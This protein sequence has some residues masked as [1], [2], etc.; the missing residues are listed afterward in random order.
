MSRRN[1]PSYIEQQL[2]DV[3]KVGSEYAATIRAFLIEDGSHIHEA[4]YERVAKEYA[5][6]LALDDVGEALD[7]AQ[8]MSEWRNKNGRAFPGA[9]HMANLIV[10]EVEDIQA[11]Y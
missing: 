5:R 8:A 3:D 6:Q 4:R 7:F 2:I 10:T 11:E 9:K 1:A